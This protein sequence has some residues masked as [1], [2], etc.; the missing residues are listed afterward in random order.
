MDNTHDNTLK[1]DNLSSA[2]QSTPERLNPPHSSLAPDNTPISIQ[3]LDQAN[4]KQVDRP[5]PSL[6]ITAGPANKPDSPFSS[7]L[8]NSSNAPY[9]GNGNNQTKKHGNNQYRWYH[10]E[11]GK[12]RYTRWNGHRGDSP[13]AEKNGAVL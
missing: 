13:H 7:A 1:S 4:A 9:T 6:M 8:S 3:D 12:T 2:C 10:K 5:K 11:Y